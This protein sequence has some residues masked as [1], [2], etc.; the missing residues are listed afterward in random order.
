MF[1]N[2]VKNTH[3]LSKLHQLTGDSTGSGFIAC[4][5][6]AE[7]IF[8]IGAAIFLMKYNFTATSLPS[9]DFSVAFKES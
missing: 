7:N 4:S 9:D 8:R 5:I 2:V 1:A 3:A 6:F